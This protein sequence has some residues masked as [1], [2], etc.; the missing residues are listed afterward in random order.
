MEVWILILI[1]AGPV[2]LLALAAFLIWWFAIRDKGN[3]P[4]RYTEVTC[5]TCGTQT[6]IDKF[7]PPRKVVCPNCGKE[8]PIKLSDMS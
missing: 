6:K 7:D 8:G 5:S 2:I 1:I 3:D 4:D